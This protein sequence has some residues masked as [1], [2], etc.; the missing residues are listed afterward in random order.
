MIDL[1]FTENED[2]DTAL[3]DLWKELE[4]ILEIRS[5][6][7][8]KRMIRRFDVRKILVEKYNLQKRIEETFI[9]LQK[10]IEEN[11]NGIED[12]EIESEVDDLSNY[13]E[14]E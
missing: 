4:K 3:E 1:P 8:K 5:K 13:S 12:S 6:V 10:K 9:D 11:R 7:T 2:N 14:S